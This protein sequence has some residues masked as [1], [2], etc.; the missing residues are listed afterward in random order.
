MPQITTGLRSIL[1]SPLFYKGLQSLLGAEKYR[2][3]ITREY[4]LNDSP[5]TLIDI[6]CGPCD[7][8]EYIPVDTRYIGVDSSRKYIE[9]AVNRFGERGTFLCLPVNAIKTA[10]NSSRL[11]QRSSP[12]RT[13]WQGN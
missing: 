2:R 1:S 12:A 11:I 10:G 9:A 13:L 8:L 7:I 3:I 4:L 5:G 6:G